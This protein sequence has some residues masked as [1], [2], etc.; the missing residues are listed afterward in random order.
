MFAIG[1]A[2]RPPLSFDLADPLVALAALADFGIGL[3]YF[4]AAA[5][6]RAGEV[7]AVTYEYGNA[8][9]IVAGLLN[10]L[11]VIDAA[12]TRPGKKVMHSHLF[13]LVLFAMFVSLVFA[14]IAEQRTR[15]DQARRPD[16]RRLPRVGHRAQLVDLPISL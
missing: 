15:T 7:R 6:V 11:V 1:L 8:F 3:T 4:I 12:T 14:V 2:A 10:V 13:L 9:L 16:V 5:G